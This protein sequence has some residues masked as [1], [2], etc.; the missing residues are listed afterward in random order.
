MLTV[1]QAHPN[2]ALI[3][4]WGKAPGPG[5]IPAAPSLSVTL[6]TLTTTTEIEDAETDAFVLDGA[7]SG[8]PKIHAARTL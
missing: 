5:N 8:D 6:D 1:T 7:P 2:I 4:Y 3:K